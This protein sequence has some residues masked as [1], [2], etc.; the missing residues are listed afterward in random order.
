MTELIS[1]SVGLYGI[2]VD[3][4]NGKIYYSNVVTNEIIIADINGASPL[5]LLN[6]SDGI[7]GPR[8]ISVDAINSKIYWAEVGSAKMKKANLDGSNIIEVV[9]G[10]IAPVDISV[11]LINNKLYW[12][13]NG[14]GQKK[15][16]RCNL[17][18]TVVEDIISGLD[19]VGGIEV[20]VVSEKIYWVDFGNT[21]KI[22]RANIDGSSTETLVTI[23]SG[24]PRDVTIDKENNKM[25]WTDVVNNNIS[26]AN[27][28]GTSEAV[29]IA[30]LSS[31]ISI[32][33]TSSVATPVEL[34]S[35]S[36]HQQN[37]NIN[38]NWETATEVNNYGF[39]VESKNWTTDEWTTIG[40]VEGNGNSNSKKQYSF[41]DYNILDGIVK[42]R[43]KQIDF[44]GSFEYSDEVEIE[45]ENNLEYKLVQNSPNPFNPTTI[46]TFSIP[47]D[48]FVTL[49]IYNVL[50]EKVDELV[51]EELTRGIHNYTW[52]A[53]NFSSGIY[54]YSISVNDFSEVIK[55]NLIK[56]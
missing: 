19:Q 43:L 10:L 47:K 52:N 56:Y 11:D 48:G 30:S 13:D 25:F 55:M 12:S 27:R 34:I 23:S 26:S 42:Y 46:I 14:T 54:I 21:D 41:A 6:A 37:N 33:S 15:I 17:D 45:I 40:F 9:T 2:T 1:S 36:I 16:S 51:N 5:V 31:P 35:F 39:E 7:D 28:D 29:I 50:G 20:D 18:G 38:L 49:S 44:D 24:S 32:N 3:Y 22:M 4:T 8:G 53:V